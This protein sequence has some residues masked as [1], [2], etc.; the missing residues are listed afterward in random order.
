MKS[1]MR[2]LGQFKDPFN[3]C[4][5]FLDTILLTKLCAVADPGFLGG[6]ATISEGA[7]TY[8]VI[9]KVRL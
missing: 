4:D 8:Y 1:A 6:K 5:R 7:P 3:I 9:V 2:E